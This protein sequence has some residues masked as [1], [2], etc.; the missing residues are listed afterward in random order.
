M[1]IAVADIKAALADRMHDLCQTLLPGGRK[2]GC[3]WVCGS[4]Q[5][6][7]G[8]SFS[9][10]LSGTK[11]GVWK[12]FAAD[13][14]G[15]P[16]ELVMAVKGCDFQSALSWSLNFLGQDPPR[17]K[18][19]TPDEDELAREALAR[20]IWDNARSTGYEPY[21]RG[22]GIT[23]T[24]PALGFASMLKHSFNYTGPAMVAAVTDASNIIRAV[25]RTWLN[26]TV[27]PRKKALGRCSGAA[28]RLAP[29]A[30]RL[31]LAE[32]IE[33]GLA[34]MMIFPDLPVWAGVGTAGMKGIMLPPEVSEVVLLSD[35]DKAGREAAIITSKRLRETG[36]KVEIRESPHGDWNDEIQT[37]KETI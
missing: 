33:T 23:I 17:R 34:A 9:A 25:H 16:F 20:E 6:D 30:A 26:Q 24:S 19:Q 37:I 27:T 5:G 29:I 18:P 11:A 3:E 21:L 32:G 35:A 14:K 22:R 36:R 13:T 15:G 28:V 1:A 31:G 2:S 10:R 4:V 7:K 12:D 8:E